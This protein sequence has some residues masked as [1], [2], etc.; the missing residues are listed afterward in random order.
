MH[1]LL[2]SGIECYAFHGCLL[3]EEKIGCN[4]TVD[5]IFTAELAAAVE[6]DDLKNTIDYVKVNELVKKEM[7]IA[8]RLIEH[9]AGRIHK[10]LLNEFPFCTKI[11]VSVGKHQPPV[12][13]YI[14]KAVFTLS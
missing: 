2:I 1:E 8:S 5:I 4:Y 10:A 11:N 6:T 7:A 3:E 14:H 9:V 13:G 12:A